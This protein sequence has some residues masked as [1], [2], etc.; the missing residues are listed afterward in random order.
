MRVA[1]SRCCKQSSAGWF[2]SFVLSEAVGS[3]ELAHVLLKPFCDT[4]AWGL[5]HTRARSVYPGMAVWSQR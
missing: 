2:H 4:E 1:K 5:F 3:G